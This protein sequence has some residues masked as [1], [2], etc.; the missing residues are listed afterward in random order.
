MYR[1]EMDFSAA[2]YFPSMTPLCP[3]WLPAN[4]FQLL[5]LLDCYYIHFNSWG[6]GANPVFHPNGCPEENRFLMA[7]EK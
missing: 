6:P 2:V 3:G 5:G 4:A 7:V 1:G